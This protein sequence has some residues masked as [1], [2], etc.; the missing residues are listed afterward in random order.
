MERV[1]RAKRDNFKSLGNS[2][3]FKLCLKSDERIGSVIRPHEYARLQ[4]C[5]LKCG[6]EDRHSTG[7]FFT[8]ST[9]ESEQRV[10]C[11]LDRVVIN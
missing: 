11:K 8:W 4:Q 6:L 10:F 7:N 3:R 5:M 9:Q 1:C 2:K